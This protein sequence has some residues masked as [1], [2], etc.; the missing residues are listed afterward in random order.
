MK[1]G[2]AMTPYNLNEKSPARK[3]FRILGPILLTIGGLLV[4]TAAGD[5]FFFS[6]HFFFLGFI[7][8]PLIFLG[9]VFT[10]LGFMGAMARYSASQTAPVAKDVTNYMLDQTQ[11]SVAHLAGAIVQEV[12]SEDTPVTCRHCGEVA[13]AGA[14]FCDRCGKPL[15]IVCPK[16]HAQND[17]NAR[18]CQKCGEPL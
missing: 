4:I 14:L 6:A 17:Q 12:K 3:V 9:S 15:A 1:E 18:Y 10:A 16:C 13:H 8:M 11:D 2:S 7:G 5:L